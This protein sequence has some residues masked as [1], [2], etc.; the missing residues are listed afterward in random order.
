MVNGYQIIRSSTELY[1][2]IRF[3]RAKAIL[4]GKK[5]PSTKV[6]TQEV[7]KL[8]DREELWQNVFKKMV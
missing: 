7:V 4:E 6:I 2:L 5:E 3:I 8:I 1:D